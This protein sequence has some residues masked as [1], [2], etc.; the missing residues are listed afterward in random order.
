MR[1]NTIIIA[2]F[3][4]LVVLAPFC[5]AQYSATQGSTFTLYTRC[6]G[7]TSTGATVAIYDN[8]DNE[9]YPVTSM[10][11][12]G[13]VLYALNVTLIN[14]GTY[15]TVETCSF[16]SGDVVGGD[17]IQISNPV[18][19]S[20]QVNLTGNITDVQNNLSALIVTETSKPASFDI[21][22]VFL[23][24]YVLLMLLAVK[25]RENWFLAMT[26]IYGIIFG[27]FMVATVSFWF[28]GILLGIGLL[29]MWRGFSNS[30]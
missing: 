13:G 18:D 11:S 19:V 28:G 14:I 4:S 7:E 22:I 16:P 17:I 24:I 1:S 10:S 29:F 20:I 5:Y 15:S 21:S 27:V 9:V 12:L 3:L 30:R 8:Q 6:V 23:L 25:I 26:G 2:L